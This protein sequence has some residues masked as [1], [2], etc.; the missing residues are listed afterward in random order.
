MPHQDKAQ[1]CFLGLRIKS[2]WSM[3]EYYF[4]IGLAISASRN[5]NPGKKSYTYIDV[6]Y[7]IFTYHYYLC[8]RYG[9][10]ETVLMD[11]G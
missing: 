4:F 9:V 3:E 11:H 2:E 6:R 1:K 7:H 10:I 8:P 5:I